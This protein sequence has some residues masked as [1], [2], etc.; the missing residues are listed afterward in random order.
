[1]LKKEIPKKEFEN[2]ELIKGQIKDDNK[3]LF[4]SLSKDT[5][6]KYLEEKN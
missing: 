5:G 6:D 2:T 4:D 3:E 1:M